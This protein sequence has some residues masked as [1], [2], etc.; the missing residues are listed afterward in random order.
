MVAAPLRL[1]LHAAAKISQQPKNCENRNDP[2]LVQAFLKKWWVE[3]DLS[4][5]KRVHSTTTLFN[6]CKIMFR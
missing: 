5:F 3:S 4:D 6:L 1:F 2:N